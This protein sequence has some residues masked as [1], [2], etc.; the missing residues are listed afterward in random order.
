[1]D[2]LLTN[3]RPVARKEYNC[4]ASDW[5]RECGWEDSDWSVDEATV[6]ANAKR[7]DWMIRKGTRYVYQTGLFDGEIV[8]FRARV[9]LHAICVR[10]NLYAA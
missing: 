3:K 10:H 2:T 8:T 5:I 1:M 4:M 6:I 9:D 7:D